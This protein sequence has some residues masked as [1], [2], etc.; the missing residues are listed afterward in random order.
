[1]PVK[2]LLYTVPGEQVDDLLPTV[3][4]VVLAPSLARAVPE[5]VCV[6]GASGFVAQEMW[7]R[8]CLRVV[9]MCT[10]LCSLPGKDRDRTAAARH[11]EGLTP[12]DPTLTLAQAPSLFCSSPVTLTL[13]LTLHPT[14]TRKHPETQPEP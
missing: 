1:M 8:S 9:L 6:T 11:R 13:T 2:R 10:A 3:P 4:A 12:C 7:S 14:P 5:S